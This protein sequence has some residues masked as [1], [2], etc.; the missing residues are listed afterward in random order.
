MERDEKK[1]VY[2]ERRNIQGIL[3]TPDETSV[4]CISIDKIGSGFNQWNPQG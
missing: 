1:I 2:T 4:S 3:I